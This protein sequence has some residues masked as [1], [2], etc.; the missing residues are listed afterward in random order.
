M[1]DCENA[2]ATSRGLEIRILSKTALFLHSGSENRK[3]ATGLMSFFA[4]VVET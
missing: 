4:A 2:V 1:V 3:K